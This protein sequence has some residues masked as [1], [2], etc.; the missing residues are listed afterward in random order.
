MPRFVLLTLLV[1]L[2][3]S[4]ELRGAEPV[5]EASQ[6]DRRRLSLSDVLLDELLAVDGTGGPKVWTVKITNLTYRQPMGPTFVVVHNS[7][8]TE[9]FTLGGTA[10]AGLTYLAEEGSPAILVNEYTGAT[11]VKSATGE[12][13]APLYEGQT[14]E[15]TVETDD[16]YPYLSLASM[17]VNTNDCFAGYNKIRPSDGMVLYSPGYDAGTEV[18]D[19]L[20]DHIPGPGCAGNTNKTDD[21]GAGEGVILVHRGMFGIGDLAQST[22]DWRNPMLRISITKA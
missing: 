16:D 21:A 1:A 8:A 17:A 3:S 15:F 18:N 6:S 22:Y 5:D 13:S 2:T 14:R 12:G 4:A 9:L 19:E 10:G 20:C 7:A 11:G